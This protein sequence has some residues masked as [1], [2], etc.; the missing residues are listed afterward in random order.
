[1]T[2]KKNHSVVEVYPEHDLIRPDLKTIF[3][4]DDRHR[5][6]PPL[7]LRQKHTRTVNFISASGFLSLSSI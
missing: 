5:V 7:H 3:R 1:M 4:G 6:V 2:R